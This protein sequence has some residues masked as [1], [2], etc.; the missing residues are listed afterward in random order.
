MKPDFKLSAKIRNLME[1]E[2]MTYGHI[3]AEA[4]TSFGTIKCYAEETPVGK[5]HDS[6]VA[7]VAGV[8]NKYEMKWSEN[9]KK[10]QGAKLQETQEKQAKELRKTTVYKRAKAVHA[11][12]SSNMLADDEKQ[13]YVSHFME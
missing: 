9:N 10:E 4:K 11:I 6:I 12:M 5:W 3:A 7:R 2:N 13:E 8:I 1:R